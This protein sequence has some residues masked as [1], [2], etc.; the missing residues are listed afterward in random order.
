MQGS[1]DATISNLRSITGAKNN[2]ELARKL[3][4]DQSTISSWRSRG[5][6]PARFVRMLQTPHEK[7]PEKHPK[8]WQ[9]LI[10]FA[11]PITAVRFAILRHDII[12]SEDKTEASAI[13]KKQYP[14]LLITN[15]VIQ[16]LRKRMELLSIDLITAQAL[17]LQDDLRNPSET[18][19]RL[20]AQLSED[21][22][23]NPWLEGSS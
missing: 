11:Q 21:M 20:A 10:D 18:H 9:E 8:V 12:L 1:V 7:L 15:R 2:A 23:D 3:S 5:R 17:V 19:K 4:V 6:V 13:L 14:F 16:E 22:A